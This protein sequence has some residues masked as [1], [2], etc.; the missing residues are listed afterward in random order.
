MTEIMFSCFISFSFQLGDDCAI[1]CAAVTKCFYV[2]FSLSR[3]LSMN[4]SSL[5]IQIITCFQMFS[6]LLKGSK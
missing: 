5:N 1:M 4:F 6:V 2:F 3:F